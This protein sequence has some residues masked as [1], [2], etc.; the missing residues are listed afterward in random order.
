MGLRFQHCVKLL[1][2]AHLNILC[3]AYVFE[4]GRF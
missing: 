2:G 4:V 1:S 3:P